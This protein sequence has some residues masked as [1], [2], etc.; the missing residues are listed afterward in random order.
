[1]LIILPRKQLHADGIR[2]HA[3]M[4]RRRTPYD[5]DQQA[6]IKELHLVQP[7]G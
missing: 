3:S 2:T 5:H 1:M 6:V 7:V 4:H